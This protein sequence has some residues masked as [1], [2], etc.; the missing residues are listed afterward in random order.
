MQTCIIS[1]FE[2]FRFDLLLD[3]A[4]K[5]GEGSEPQF[6]VVDP[7]VHYQSPLPSQIWMVQAL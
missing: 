4:V 5:I 6:M 1:Y 3:N 7:G 2:N